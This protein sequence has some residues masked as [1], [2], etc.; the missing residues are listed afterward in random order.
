MNAQDHA[1]LQKSVGS[2]TAS[3]EAQAQQLKQQIDEE[4]R[5]AEMEVQRTQ[6][7]KLSSTA[8]RQSMEE[9]AILEAAAARKLELEQKSV[10]L[11]REVSTQTTITHTDIIQAKS[12]RHATTIDRRVCAPCFSLYM[13]L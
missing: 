11:Q 8:A 1:N 6:Q 7:E 13:W 9:K 2:A 10:Q 4:K 5:R 12:K 3:L